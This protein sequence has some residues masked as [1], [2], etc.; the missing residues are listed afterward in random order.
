MPAINIAEIRK[1]IVEISCWQE[2]ITERQTDRQTDPT[3]Y[4]ISRAR[5]D[6]RLT[7][8]YFTLW[9]RTTFYN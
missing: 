8:S 4:I 1:L 9:I 3:E 2:M 6:C 5:Y 7:M